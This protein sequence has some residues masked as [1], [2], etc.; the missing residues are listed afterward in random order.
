[1]NH[2]I[3]AI[4][5]LAAFLIL[6]VVLGLISNDDRCPECGGT[7]FDW[8]YDKMKCKRDGQKDVEHKIY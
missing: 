2:H 6:F 8:S 4:V 7:L 3:A 5:A 1:M